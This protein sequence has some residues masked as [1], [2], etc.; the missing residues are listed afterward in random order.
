[1]TVGLKYGNTNTYFVDGLLIDTD[2]PGTLGGF[3]A[4]L[5]R[6]GLTLGDVRYVLVTHYHPD[7]VGLIGELT[8]R[9]VGLL[10]LER[11]AGFLHAPDGVFARMRGCRFTPIDESKATVIPLEGSRDFLSTLGICGE[12]LPTD[13]HSPDGVALV[14]DNGE[15]F[16]GDLEPLAFLDGYPDN[17]PLRDDWTRIRSL[18]ARVIHSGHANDVTVI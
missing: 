2:L 18:G 1:M 10:V 14:L 15:A 3:F 12:I 16:V 9:G 5:G 7:H 13:S 8:A 6:A 4:A 11:Q 17:A